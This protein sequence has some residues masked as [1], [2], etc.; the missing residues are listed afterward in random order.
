VKYVVDV[1]DTSLTSMMRSA[2]LT[3]DEMVPN[4]APTMKDK[5]TTYVCP[6]DLLKTPPPVTQ[7]PTG[8][9]APTKA[10]GTVD[11]NAGTIDLKL[12]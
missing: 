4:P 10:V 5:W 2:G 11:L 9:A 12:S 3:M 8:T 1:H 6:P 7:P